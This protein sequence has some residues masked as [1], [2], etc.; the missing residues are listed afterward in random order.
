M[1]SKLFYVFK[2][3]ICI[4]STMAKQQEIGQGAMTWCDIIGQRCTC[5][6]V[7]QTVHLFHTVMSF[8]D[9][10]TSSLG[11]ALTLC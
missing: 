10:E 4:V 9:N 3:Y 11:Q 6:P 7:S 2:A 5:E 1:Y 8:W